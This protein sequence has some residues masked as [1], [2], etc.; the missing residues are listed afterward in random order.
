MV[1]HQQR[2]VDEELENADKLQKLTKFT[3]TPT[4]DSLDKAEKS[5][6][7][8]QILIMRLFGDVLNDRINAFA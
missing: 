7:K 3:T 8:R 1:P 2:V 6:L 5:R 4:F